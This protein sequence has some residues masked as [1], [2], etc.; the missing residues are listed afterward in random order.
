MVQQTLVRQVTGINPALAKAR[1]DTLTKRE[2]QVAEKLAKGN[3]NAEIAVDL[4]ISPK[5][6]DI[7]RSNVKKKLQVRTLA[8][9][10]M[11]YCAVQFRRPAEHSCG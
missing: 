1:W 8:G 7:H 10:A 5:T 4:F 11:V 3:L 2:R 6:L 9:I